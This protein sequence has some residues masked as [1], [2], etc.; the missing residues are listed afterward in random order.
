MP[1]IKVT[2]PNTKLVHTNLQNLA[3]KIPRVGRQA[4]WEVM[5]AALAKLQKPG[6]KI[7]YPVRWDSEKQRRAYFATKGF[8]HGIPYRR[9]GAYNKAWKLSAQPS[10]RE[11]R[12]G[13][14]ISNSLSYAKYVGGNAAGGGQSNIHK[15]RWVLFRD[16]MEKELQKLPAKLQEYLRLGGSKLK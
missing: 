3:D 7:T 13:Y 16:V 6:R 15:D 10:T 9:T 5:Q 1:Q 4:I 8:G 2:S 12:T 11:G 14:Q